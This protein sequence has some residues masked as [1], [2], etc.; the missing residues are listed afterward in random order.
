M[1]SGACCV[2]QIAKEKR[3]QRLQIKRWA[4]RKVWGLEM[5]HDESERAVVVFDDFLREVE[6]D[7]R[8]FMAVAFVDKRENQ[9]L[10]GNKR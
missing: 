4:L 9:V 5:S 1:C 2:A 8:R 6:L 3:L 7:G 10:D